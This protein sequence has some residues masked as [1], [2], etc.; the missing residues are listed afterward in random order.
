M[1]ILVHHL[2]DGRAAYIQD[3]GAPIPPLARAIPVVPDGSN[4]ASFGRGPWA[5]GEPAC[6]EC[7]FAWVAI[8]PAGCTE[9][10]LE[11]LRCGGMTGALP[12]MEQCLER[13]CRWKGYAVAHPDA[14]R[15]LQC[16]K[17]RE[18]TAVVVT[19]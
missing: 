6:Y 8:T 14:P 15:K 10:A 19:A 17:C 4:V 7:S 16:P 5:V 13:T 12:K 18:M 2:S 3:T 11:C 9:D 1:R